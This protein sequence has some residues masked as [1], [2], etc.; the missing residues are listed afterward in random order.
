MAARARKINSISQFQ[1]A[2]PS[3]VKA[4]NA[5]PELALRAAANPLMAVEELGYTIAEDVRKEAERLVRFKPETAERLAAL[6]E[7]VYELAGESF[8][9]DSGEAL[10][11]VLFQKLKLTPPEEGPGQDQAQ[12]QRRPPPSKPPEQRKIT[13]PLPPRVLGHEP[14]PDPLEPLRGAHPVIEPLLEYRQLEASSARLA[15]PELYERIR[16]GEVEL[17][18]SRIRYTLQRGFTPE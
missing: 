9:I 18:V 16:R 14:I 6:E 17:P 10:A 2:V 8:A 12:Q 4:V 5:D 11:H 13:D 1:R 7:Q 3:I 15:P